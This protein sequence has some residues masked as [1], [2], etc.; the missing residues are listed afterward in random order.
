MFSTLDSEAR[1][2]LARVAA[3]LS[4]APGE[5]AA[6]EGDDRA[7]FAVLEG[8]IEPVKTVDGIKRKTAE[9]PYFCWKKFAR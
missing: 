1:E 7:L 3:D 4:L 9:M 8:V 2:R 6:N 5:F